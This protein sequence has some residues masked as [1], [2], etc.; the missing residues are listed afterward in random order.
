M[1]EL[2]LELFSEEI[3]ARMQGRAAEDLKRLVTD[4][5]KAAGLAFTKAEAFAT[6]RRL[7]LVVEG[8]PLKQP[9]VSEERKGP[10]VGS[11]EKALEGFIRAAGLAHIAEAEQRDTGKGIFYFATSKREGRPTATVL[12]EILPPAVLALPW[13]K[14]MRWG[15]HDMR[16]VRPLHRLLCILDR[17]IVPIAIGH[18]RAGGVTQGHRFLAPAKIEVADFADYRAKLRAAHVMLDPAERRSVILAE[19]ERRAAAEKLTLVEDGGLLDE[20]TGLVEWPVVLL[21]SID[22]SFMD[23]PREVLSTAMRAHQ[24]YFSLQAA[25]GRLAPRFG[26]VANMLT[27]DG[28]RQIVAGN[29]KVLRARLSDA[30]FFW[31]QDRKNRLWPGSSRRTCRVPMQPGSRA[32][33]YWPRPISPPAW[34]ANSRSC[35]GSWG[36][37]TRGTM[38]RRRPSPMPSPSTTSRSAR[39]TAARRRR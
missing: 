25:D 36:A 27:E 35:R 34:S 30:K 21:G 3:P 5:L 38:A 31:D 8:L 28:G 2:L 37:T 11:P 6:P 33:R 24:K 19:L 12:A 15:A 7:A 18:V 10:R 14:S 1:A 20:V 22:Q 39:T 32:A 17:G 16:W 23:V 4:A 29:E 9:D 13:P 26:L